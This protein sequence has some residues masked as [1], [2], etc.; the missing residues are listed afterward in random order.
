MG[1]SV[2]V[3]IGDDMKKSN[4]IVASTKHGSNQSQVHSFG[5]NSRLDDLHAGILSAKA[6]TYRCLE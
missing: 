6:Q 1:T 3:G 5:F 2:T 4:T